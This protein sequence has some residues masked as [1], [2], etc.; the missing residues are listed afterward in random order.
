MS[1]NVISIKYGKKFED[2]F[3]RDWLKSFPD[4][5]LLRLHDQMSGYKVVSRNP[6]DFICF[7]EP[8]L[9][10]V[11]CKS[12]KGAS[13]PFDAIPQ[14]DDLLAYKDKPGV[15]PGIVIWFI[16]KDLVIWVPITT[17]EKIYTI[18]KSIGIRHLDTYPEIKII[19]GVK[20]RKYI[21]SDY[22]IMVEE[23]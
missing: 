12:H 18:S 11:E 20:L 16:D 2:M 3:E 9:F 19:P 15:Y 6:C 7:V 23:R 21:S 17:A 10:L 8:K 4:S 1:A 13:I 5:L 14:Y 22:S